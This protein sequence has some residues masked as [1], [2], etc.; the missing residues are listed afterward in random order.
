[1][2]RK[3]RIVIIAISIILV[4]LV[5]LGVL[6]YL[7]LKTDA[8]KSKETLFAKY[9]AQNFNSIEILKT[10]SD[11]EIENMLNTNKYES[12]LEGTIEYTEDIGTSNENKNSN[13]NNVGIKIKSNVDK[14]NNYD[15]KDISIENK[16]E[17]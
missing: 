16:Y 5:I 2:P 3:K 4:M 14:A 9:L 11:S 7:Y 12:Q 13:I 8:F 17:R 15:Y 6:G 10:E 1:M